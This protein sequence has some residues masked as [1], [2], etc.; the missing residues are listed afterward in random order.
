VSKTGI[1]RGM[2]AA[3]LALTACGEAA[4]SPIPQGP[5]AAPAPAGSPVARLQGPPETPKESLLAEARKRVLTKDDF[6]ESDTNRDPFRSFLQ[7]FAVQTAVRTQHEI[8]FQ[9]FALDELKLIAVITG[10]RGPARAM[11]IDPSGLGMTV[12]RGDHLS[13][14]DALIT[15]IAPDRVFFRIEEDAGNEKP[16]IVERVLE[17]H[18]GEAAAQ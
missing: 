4:N 15:R 10:E 14:A 6:T 5:K 7:T 13:K 17:L 2:L 9:K 1:V 16:R 18:A 8:K 11:F 3:S 12:G